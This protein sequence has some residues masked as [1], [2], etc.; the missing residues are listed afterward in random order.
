M[1]DRADPA[2]RRVV[3]I[4]DD[5]ELRGLI[6]VMLEV[7]ARFRMVGQAGDGREGV[8]LVDRLQP[9][10]I[11]LD[12]HLP[13]MDGLTALPQLRAAAPDARIVVFSAFPDPYTL[14]EVVGLGADAYLDK[15]TA[16]S[17]LLTTID[18]VCQA[19]EVQSV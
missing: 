5:A 8:A 13:G 1:N 19:D 4:D 7:D 14:L 16:W 3:V 9:D 12:L 10:V 17:Q 6:E 11:I 18:A 15:A 2:V